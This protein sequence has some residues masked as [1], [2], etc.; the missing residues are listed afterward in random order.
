MKSPRNRLLVAAMASTLFLL[1]MGPQGASADDEMAR[2]QLRDPSNNPVGVVK[3][4]EEDG[5][6][7]IRAKITN[8]D[9]GFH[10]FHVHA[11]GACSPSFTAAGGHYNPGGA[12][13]GSHAGDL[14]S[15]LVN[16][17]RTGQ[18]AFTTDR[19]TLA[20]LLAGDGSAFIV[21]GNRDNFANIPATAVV[22][23]ATV[24]RYHS[25]TENVFG[26]DSAT[27]ATG[28]AGSRA[29]C[30]VIEG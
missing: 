26:P 10:G 22:S 1:A 28:D 3:L 24:D 9:P 6:V 20:E 30:G 14:P 27:R 2:A 12:S 18:I 25:H 7:L 11:T 17:D 23:G 19:F 21:H 4:T 29:A 16:S 8:L 5:R 15:I 13:H